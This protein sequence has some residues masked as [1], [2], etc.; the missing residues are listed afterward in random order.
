VLKVTRA[1]G[2]LVLDD[3]GRLAGAF[4]PISA[5]DFVAEDA[6]RGFV[7]TQGAGRGAV[8]G[9]TLRLGADRMAVQRIGPLPRSV[10]S[11]PDPDPALT[12]RV[13]AVLQAFAQGGKTVETVS[14]LAPRARTDYARGPSPELVGIRGIS[15]VAAQDVE[16]RGIERHGARVRRVLYYRFSSNRG[17]RY[18]LVYLTVEGLVTDQDVVED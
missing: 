6:D 14:G 10:A 9:M 5:T 2:S 11:R 12:R 13:E 16:G 17:G 1:D 18:V 3:G 8:T 7:L 4:L 15:F